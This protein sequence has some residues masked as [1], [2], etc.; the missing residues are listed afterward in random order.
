M[1]TK[2][3]KQFLKKYEAGGLPYVEGDPLNLPGIDVDYG[4]ELTLGDPFQTYKSKSTKKFSFPKINVNQA[5]AQVENTDLDT[6]LGA[7][8]GLGKLA[9]GTVNLLEGIREGKVLKKREKSLK[10]AQD[11]RMEEAR[12]DD[13]YYTPYTVGRTSDR[14]QDGGIPDRYK[15][16]GFTKV[17]Q[18]KDSTRD[19]KKWMVLAKKDDK[20]KVVHGGYEGMED[21]SQHK[22]EKRRENFW[23][24]MGGKDSAKAKDPFSPLYYHRTRGTWR[25]GGYQSGGLQDFLDYY[26]QDQ[27]DNV[28]AQQ[29]MMGMED[30]EMQGLIDSNNQMRQQ[31]IQ[32]IVGGA[33][34]TAKIAAGFFQLGGIKTKDSLSTIDSSNPNVNLLPY[35]LEE[36]KR[37]QVKAD[38]ILNARKEFLEDRAAS[39]FP[40]TGN[41]SNKVRMMERNHEKQEGGQT[42]DLYSENFQSP[43]QEQAPVYDPT[44]DYNTMVMDWIFSDQSAGQSSFEEPTIFSSMGVPAAPVVDKLKAMGINPSSVNTGK[45]NEGSLHYQ[46]RAIDLGLNTSFGG[47]MRKMK[48]FYNYLNSD[49]GKKEFPGVKVVDESVRPAG[50]KV[51]GGSH[52]HLEI[53]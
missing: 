53:Q 21:F 36:N 49:E 30:Q 26:N 38:N 42:E 32:D 8:P 13:F 7:V 9:L 45:H 44:E 47:D 20:Y 17:G 2:K 29:N 52:L 48:A 34:D 22:D 27:K 14:L 23:N 31:G 51:W 46:G 37:E 1:L 43:Y 11:R 35:M 5:Q 24:R 19:G 6:V 33:F 25:D 15:E 41:S 28:L 10:K 3:A 4:Q 18:K 12:G 50:Q 16:M 40:V 39:G